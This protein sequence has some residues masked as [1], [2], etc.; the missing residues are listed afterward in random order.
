MAHPGKE[1][2][3]SL[4]GLPGTFI[5]LF[6]CLFSCLFF[7]PALQLLLFFVTYITQC[8]YSR[9]GLRI[10]GG[11]R[12]DLKTQPGRRLSVRRVPP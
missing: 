4:I 12:M 2:R 10:P 11:N 9:P 1:L 8:Q 7:F 5:C 6:Q 3:F